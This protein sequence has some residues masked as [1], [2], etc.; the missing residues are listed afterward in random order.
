MSIVVGMR[1]FISYSHRGHGPEWKSRLVSALRIFEAHHLLDVWQDGTIRVSSFWDDDI[2]QAIGTARL[3]VVLLTK[4]ALESQY[5]VEREFPLLRERQQLGLLRVFP[6]VCEECGWKSHDWLRAT[7]APNESK[8]LVQLSTVSQDRVLRQLA[9][10]IATALSE[11]ALSELFPRAGGGETRTYLETF[12]LTHGTGQREETLIGREQELALLDFALAQPKTAIVSLVAWGGVGK[13]MLVRHWLQRLHRQGW[14]GARRVYAWSFHSQGTKEDRQASEDTF[15]AHALEWFG[16]QCEPTL[17]PWDKGRLLAD[18]VAS[19]RTL[20]VLDGIEPLQYPPGPMGGQLRA[21]GVQSLLKHLAR[22]SNESE[23]RGLC[24]LTTR[25]PITDLADF[26]RRPSAAWGSVLGVDLGNLTDEAGAALLH[27]AGAKRAG[28]AEI[29]ADDAELLAASSEVDGHA[30]TLNLLGRFLARTH[31]G[32]VRHRDLVKFE[33]ADRTTQGGTTFRMLAAF[34][35]WFD[36]GS[37]LYKQQLAILRVLGLFDRPADAGCIAVLRTP[38][39]MVGFTDSLFTTRIDETSG[40][41]FSQPLIE[42]DWNTATSFL[43]GFGLITLQTRDGDTE[44]FIDCHALIRGY[45][46]NQMRTRSDDNWRSAHR[47]LF[48]HLRASAEDQPETLQALQPLYQAISHAC[49]AGLYR[50][51]VD[52]I[53]WMRILRGLDHHS[54]KTLGASGE[55]LSALACFF[56]IPWTQLREGLLPEQQGL[57]LHQSAQCLRFLGRLAEAVEP[58]Q[59]VLKRDVESWAW[60]DAAMS[61]NLLGELSLLLGHTDEALRVAQQSVE[62]ADRNGYVF[63]SL[64]NRTTVGDVLHQMGRRDE[65]INLFQEAEALHAKTMPAQPLL[66]SLGG[67]QYSEVLLGKPERAAWNKFLMRAVAGRRRSPSAGNLAEAESSRYT[68]E[69]VYD[70]WCRSIEDAATQTL[71]WE[72]ETPMD[73]F[74]QAF[75]QL[76]LGHASLV[77]LVLVGSAFTGD[78]SALNVPRG[79]LDLSMDGLRRSDLREYLVHALLAK[80]WLR[81]LEG[82]TDGAR[83]DLDEAW[84]I[85]ERGPM[86][87]RLADLHLHRARLF[88]RQKPYP[89]TSPEADLNAAETLI[90]E[91]GYHRRDEELADAK[92]AIL[93]T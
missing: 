53:Y 29:K 91:C 76:S 43:E 49:N 88:F 38:P 41:A 19:E 6:V 5:I 55:D 52:E 51:A 48:E 70:R 23:H 18:A 68:P 37:E 31:A 86:R 9:T 83:A 28:A 82:D 12:L 21:P 84:D 81:V 34:E 46:A 50:V 13:T 71:Q 22:K 11:L 32:D 15:L 63:Y 85:A 20:L 77:R 60:N 8:P 67:M 54:W 80:A 57:L 92:R 4:E 72:M 47:R 35:Y 40:Q 7:Q 2:R 61:A 58:L 24:L 73:S 59:V 27:H 42:E 64:A 1:V 87:L 36:R 62:F 25:E 3:A 33:E 75:H 17:S 10:D 14:L 69:G 44:C 39:V 56:E 78:G 45:F 90:N 30:L 74:S 79:W 65:A 26:Q 16:V 93:R 66:R 89:W